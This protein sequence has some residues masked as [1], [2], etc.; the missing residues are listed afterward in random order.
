MHFLSLLGIQ[1]RTTKM[2]MLIAAVGGSIGIF[3]IF[4]I[5]HALTDFDGAM[6]ILPSMG[7]AAVLLFAVPHGPLSQPWALF[8]GNMLG[9]LAGVTAALLINDIL[10][11]SAV[12]VGGAIFLTHVFRCTHP[13]AGATA[14]A[15]VIG[16]ESL[17]SL[18]YWY[19]LT[20]TLL[21]CL[22]LML[23]AMLFNN[24]FSWRRYPLALM[25]FERTPFNNPDTRR[26]KEHHIAQAISELDMVVDIGASQLK[27]IMDKADA[28]MRAEKLA[29]FDLELGAFYTNGQMGLPWS[30][31]Q[32][33][34]LKPHL[35]PKQYEIIYRTVAGKH[36]GHTG[37]ASLEDFASWAKQKLKRLGHH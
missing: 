11:A 30:V 3:L 18:G 32:I 22:V 25:R 36:R 29:Q 6:A 5:S 15:A 19:V 9:A 37:S 23:T 12:A 20:P 8:V 35:D 33:V 7:A 28:L 14:L 26:I 10:L 21:N 17:R 34:E 13:P 16:G 27:T 2:E 24:V 4:Y 1:P 31:R